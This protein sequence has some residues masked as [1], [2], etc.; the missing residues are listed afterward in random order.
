MTKKKEI[1]GKRRLHLSKE[2]DIF[3]ENL[4]MLIHAG[5]PISASL[6]TLSED[7]NSKRL[8]K[9]IKEMIAKIDEGRPFWETLDESGIASASTISLIKTG[10]QGGR[11]SENLQLVAKQQQ[12]QRVFKSHLKSAMLYPAIVLGLAFIVGFG[13]AWFILP[14]LVNIFSGLNVSLPLPT[15]VLIQT[16]TYIQAHGVE[17]LIAVSILLT[18]VTATIVFIAPIRNALIKL[19]Q[20]L[21]GI[22][23]LTLEVEIAQMGYLMGT[24]LQA[25]LP[26]DNVL[27]AVHESTTNNKFKR[28]YRKLSNG[29]EQ[30]ETFQQLLMKDKIAGKL[31]PSTV[32][33]LISAGEQ[34]GS[35]PAAFLQIANIYEEKIDTTSKNLAIILEPILL[36]AV[37]LV[38]VVLALAII[39]PIYSL[40]SNLN[41]I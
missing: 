9:V 7:L 21:P 25:G 40:I 11:L 27:I 23:R 19:L 31:L 32:V 39:L 4:S 6:S 12:K 34:S 20:T 10:E 24:L 13:V 36:V 22:R 1:K 2:A 41:S 17:V 14:K 5:V 18:I 30:G 3:I 35:L 26:V 37:W 28:L 38:V 8:K 33:S 16:G 29:I 15:R